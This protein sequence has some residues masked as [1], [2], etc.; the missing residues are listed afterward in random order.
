M[1][2][3]L[4][5]TKLSVFYA[6]SLSVFLI[7]GMGISSS[8]KA[9]SLSFVRDIDTDDL[10]IREYF[11]VNNTNLPGIAFP[12]GA[13]TLLF[14]NQPGGARLDLVAPPKDINST[15]TRTSIDITDPIN[16]AFDTK[17]RGARGFNMFRLFIWNSELDQLV[18][19]KT[20]PRNIIKPRS[21]SDVELVKKLDFQR[22]GVTNPQGMTL[23]PATGVLYVLD[24]S[25]QQIISIKR[26]IGHQCNSVEISQIIDIPFSIKG[27]LRGLAYNPFNKHLYVMNSVKRTLYKL[28]LNG[29]LIASIDLTGKKIGLPQAM[30]F[31]PSLDQTDH[32]S[33]FHLYLVTTQNGQSEFTEWVLQ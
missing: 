21:R 31:G 2:S 19:I 5:K 11:S 30:I 16:I 25:E 12:P 17:S 27:A 26:K 28:A 23:D 18:C 14:L 3:H 24:E 15:I 8:V 1:N 22:V 32:V 13:Q 33:I 9:E 20:G 29:K 6:I 10:F 7:Y 4:P